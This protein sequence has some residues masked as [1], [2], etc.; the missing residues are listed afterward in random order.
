MEYKFPKPSRRP[1]EL[2][3]FSSV[4][5]DQVRKLIQAAPS[6]SCQLDP[7]PT[8]LLKECLDVLLPSITKIVNLCL[9]E[10]VFPD[11]FKTAFVKPLLKKPSLDKNELKNY[12]P[13]SNLSFLSKV[14][15]K[16]VAEQINSH[17]VNNEL[18]NSFQSA[19]KKYHSTETALLKISNDIQLAMNRREVTSQQS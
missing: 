8:S 6:K 2:G 9:S 19:Y 11:D 13:V 3:K 4:S 5:E 18:S 7:I 16:V 17:L 10:G 12:R 15:E 1:C 14:V